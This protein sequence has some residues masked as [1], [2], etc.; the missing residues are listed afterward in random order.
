MF[1]NIDP[2]IYFSKFCFNLEARD[3]CSGSVSF[4]CMFV[5]FIEAKMIVKVRYLGLFSFV[6]LLENAGQV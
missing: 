5:F 2:N 3:D 1:S 4:L 6:Y